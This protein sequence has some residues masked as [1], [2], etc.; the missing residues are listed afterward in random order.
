MLNYR[1][2]KTFALANNLVSVFKF[3]V[4]LLVIGVLFT[5]FKPQNLYDQGFCICSTAIPA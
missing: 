4:P 5:F 3:I 1:S 2:V